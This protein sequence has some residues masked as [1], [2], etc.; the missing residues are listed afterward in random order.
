[1][2]EFRENECLPNLELKFNFQK[3]WGNHSHAKV[4]FDIDFEMVS[5]ICA[6]ARLAKIES[7]W[8]CSGGFSYTIQDKFRDS[9]DIGFLSEI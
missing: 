7:V 8:F 4:R 1:M 2:N 6:L 9:C 3:I 5:S